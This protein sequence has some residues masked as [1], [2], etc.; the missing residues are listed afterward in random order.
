MGRGGAENQNSFQRGSK[1]RSPLPYFS[2][3]NRNETSFTSYKEIS[4]SSPLS[5]L[6]D[7]G[8]FS[9]AFWL[10]T[11]ETLFAFTFALGNF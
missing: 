8:D 3:A 6:S 7:I 11:I 2:A 9:F 4:F 5:H 1:V 10:C